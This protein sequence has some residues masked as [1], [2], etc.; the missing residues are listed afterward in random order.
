MVVIDAKMKMV[1][2]AIERRRRR[3]RIGLVIL[4]KSMPAEAR[5][6]ATLD[7]KQLTE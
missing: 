3:V 1:V 2:A 7:G 4:R 6:D 5:S